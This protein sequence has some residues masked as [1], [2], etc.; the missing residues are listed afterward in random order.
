[1]PRGVYDRK[2]SKKLG[3]PKKLNVESMVAELR[4]TPKKVPALGAATG[5]TIAIPA[6]RS[7]VKLVRN[8]T[9][10]G[11]F[12]VDDA[13]CVFLRNNAKPSRKGRSLMKW[14]TLAALFNA[15]IE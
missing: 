9:V 14:S 12:I 10:I 15:G 1:M 3:R 6:G 7:H 4:A 5:V 2:K 11:T 13:G 8:N